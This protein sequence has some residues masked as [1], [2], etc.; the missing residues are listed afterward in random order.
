MSRDRPST[1]IPPPAP[2]EHGT[3][4]ARELVVGL[5]ARDAA[6]ERELL[7][8]YTVH[9][10]RVIARITGRL[11]V[12]DLTQEV[13]IRVVA[14]ITKLRDPDSLPGYVTQVAVFVAREALRA[15]RRKRWLVFLAPTALPEVHAPAASEDVKS[16]IDAFY[17][18]VDRL[19]P[20]ERISFLLRHVEGLELTEVADACGISLATTKRRLA[21]A[22]RLFKAH[23]EGVPDL[24][25]W[26]ARSPKWAKA[27]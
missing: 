14:R 15:R 20:D 24:E 22:E 3:P 10:E 6:A 12:D 7:D 13:F 23:A 27:T 25:T 16:A 4:A 17:R 18:L 19:E 2:S 11:D 21:A 5:A 8:R 1:K 9:V 26:L